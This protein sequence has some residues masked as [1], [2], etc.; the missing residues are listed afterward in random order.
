MVSR[1]LI[2]HSVCYVEANVV[3]K[4]PTP[5]NMIHVRKQD[6]MSRVPASVSLYVQKNSLKA[7]YMQLLSSHPF[8]LL[9]IKM[10]YKIKWFIGYIKS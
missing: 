9:E 7:K 3:S 2:G 1:L 6:L 5:A 4:V 10:V 8:K